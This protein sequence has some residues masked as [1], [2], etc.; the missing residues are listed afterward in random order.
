MAYIKSRKHAAPR[1]SVLSHPAAIGL[2]A[3][4]MPVAAQTAEPTNK[5]EGVPEVTLPPVR[6]K[7]S[8]TPTVDFK[9]DTV[10]SP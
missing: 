2:M 1:Q 3:F 4:A 5:P 10:A 8:A 7:A 9:A 6:A